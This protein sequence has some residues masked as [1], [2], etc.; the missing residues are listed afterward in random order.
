MYWLAKLTEH[1]KGSI[2]YGE[3]EGAEG[4]GGGTLLYEDL[5]KS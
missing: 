2:K 3:R 5:M 4:G 1:Y